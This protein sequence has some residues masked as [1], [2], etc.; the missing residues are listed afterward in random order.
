MSE[1]SVMSQEDAKIELRS[2]YCDRNFR[3]NKFISQ[4]IFNDHICV[5]DTFPD[6]QQF[7][8]TVRRD[9]P[10]FHVMIL[11]PAEYNM[12][13]R[14]LSDSQSLFRRY[15]N[16]FRPLGPPI[17]SAQFYTYNRYSFIDCQYSRMHD[18]WRGTVLYNRY[19]VFS[20]A[21]NAVE[22]VYQIFHGCHPSSERPRSQVYLRPC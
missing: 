17:S 11:S 7:C 2:P 8:S 16:H 6:V 12:L 20:P 3:P 18:Y 19:E 21:F 22:G 13:T 10:R 4:K 1:D 14:E 15:R 5:C 9:E